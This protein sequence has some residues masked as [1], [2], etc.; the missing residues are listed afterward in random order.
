MT[1]PV[2]DR[3]SELYMKVINC[4]KCNF[5][6]A[7]VQYRQ[8]FIGGEGSDLFFWEIVLGRLGNLRKD[9]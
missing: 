4:D 8:K 6:S 7:V 5:V 1:E 2:S 9:P 3:K